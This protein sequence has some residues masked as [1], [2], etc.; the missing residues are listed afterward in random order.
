M[1]ISPPLNLDEQLSW[2]IG[3]ASKGTQSSKVATLQYGR[4]FKQRASLA[5]NPIE[6]KWSVQVF[7]F[8]PWAWNHIE[9]HLRNTKAGFILWTDPLTF[10]KEGGFRPKAWAVDGEWEMTPHAPNLIEVKLNLINYQ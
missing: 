4:G 3:Y 7:C 1:A 2:S 9:F 5:L 6:E 8:D 10:F